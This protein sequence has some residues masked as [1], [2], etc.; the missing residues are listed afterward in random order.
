MSGRINPAMLDN[1]PI[2]LRIPPKECAACGGRFI[3]HGK[4]TKYCP[5]C[6]KLPQA[7]RE[8]MRD[9]RILDSVNAGKPDVV[10]Y[11]DKS[12]IKKKEKP[13]EKEAKKEQKQEAK[14]E[15]A[16]A[17]DLQRPPL[18]DGWMEQQKAMAEE[19]Q[20]EDP[21]AK[22]AR[23][24]LLKKM[25]I[26]IQEQFGVHLLVLEDVVLVQISVGGKAYSG[27]WMEKKAMEDGPDD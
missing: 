13:V 4:N 10:T 12:R 8:A 15:P 27:I 20:Q 11:I 25:M 21:S 16:L 7:Q 2:E 26:F 14:K 5:S 18:P 23:D 24:V 19:D 17:E 1:G 6:R 9:A 3:P 22:A